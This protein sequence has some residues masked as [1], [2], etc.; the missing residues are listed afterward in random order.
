MTIPK[1]LH[2][3]RDYSANALPFSTFGL[4]QVPASNR[5]TLMRRRIS[6]THEC[7]SAVESRRISLSA[8]QPCKDTVNYP[9]IRRSIVEWLVVLGSPQIEKCAPFSE[10]NALSS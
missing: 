3:P 5:G 1:I 7:A 4:L 10:H 2:K 9:D 8:P 6:H